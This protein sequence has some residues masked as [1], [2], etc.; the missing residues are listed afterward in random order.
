M[1]AKPSHRP[2]HSRYYH[3]TREITVDKTILLLKNIVITLFELEK[4]VIEELPQGGLLSFPSPVYLFI[5]AVFNT[6]HS[7]RKAIDHSGSISHLSYIDSHSKVGRS[8]FHS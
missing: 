6:A 7:H 1:R 4:V 5:A 2:L 3:T 8:A